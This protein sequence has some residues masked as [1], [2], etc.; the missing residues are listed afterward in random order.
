MAEPLPHAPRPRVSVLMGIYNCAT[1]L[2]EA[3]ESIQGQTYRDW[4][5]ILC[6]DGSSDGSLALA[7]SLAA[8]DARIRVIRNPRN[9]GLA[10]TLDHCASVARGDYFARMDGDDVSAPGRLAKLV[11]AL[12]SHPELALVSSWM[13]RFDERGDWGEVRT[14]PHPSAEDFLGGSPFCHAPCMMRREAFE[15]AGGYGKDPWIIRAEDYNLWFKFYA[16]GFRGMNLQEPLYR[17]RDDQDAYARRTLRSRLNET[18]VR[19]RGLGLIGFSPWKRL[20]SVKPLLVWAVPGFAYRWLR[21]R[22]S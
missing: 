19:W 5:L 12:D 17:V 18:V 2:R 7:E 16:L 9:L 3:V 1:T 13:T 20:W 10:Q 4:E 6:D 11:D 14:K 15:R 21:R 22:R 8:Q